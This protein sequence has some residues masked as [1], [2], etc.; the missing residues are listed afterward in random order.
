MPTPMSTKFNIPNS[1]PK[2]LPATR[3]VIMLAMINSPGIPLTSLRI[4][5]FDHGVQEIFAVAGI[6]AAFFNYL[7]QIIS[8]T[9][10]FTYRLSHIQIISHTDY[11]THRLSYVMELFLHEDEPSGG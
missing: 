5:A 2:Y 11:L 9:D 8:H 1:S 10:Y 4:V 6:L 3:N 7:I